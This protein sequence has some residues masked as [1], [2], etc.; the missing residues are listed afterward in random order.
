MAGVTT[1]SLSFGA[2][3]L[4]LLPMVYFLL[5]SLTFFLRGFDD[6]VVT[7]MLRGLFSVYF[8]AAILACGLAVTAFL[9]AGRP[10]VAGLLVVLLLIDLVARRFFLRRIDAGIRVRDAGA[11]G[12][13]R[14]LRRLHLGGIAWNAARLTVLLAAVPRLF[15]GL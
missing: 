14:G 4:L 3:I 5:A 10:V 9:L 8:T 13:L 2:T 7:W 6:P 15:P 1:Q 12:A 11:P